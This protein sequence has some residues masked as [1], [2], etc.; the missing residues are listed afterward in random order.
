MYLKNKCV[1]RAVTTNIKCRLQEGLRLHPQ[2]YPALGPLCLNLERWLLMLQKDRCAPRDMQKTN[3]VVHFSSVSTR[4][5]STD[6][7]I[8]WQSQPFLTLSELLGPQVSLPG[9]GESCGPVVSIFPK[10]Q[11]QAVGSMSVHC[12]CKAIGF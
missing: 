2:K 10:V 3:C 4:F 11:S 7:Y 5:P 8:V 9:D 6:N 12:T 1:L